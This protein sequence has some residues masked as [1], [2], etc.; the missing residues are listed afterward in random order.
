[1]RFNRQFY[2]FKDVG[3][4]TTEKSIHDMLNDFRHMFAK[5]G[6]DWFEEETRF[7]VGDLTFVV[8]K[9]T[10]LE[11]ADLPKNPINKP[12][13]VNYREGFW[14]PL[15][16]EGKYIFDGEIKAADIQVNH[17]SIDGDLELQGEDN[18]VSYTDYDD[19]WW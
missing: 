9:L 16:H 2:A 3:T 1:M 4:D 11:E 5:S 6:A 18:K 12:A 7:E 8:F 14:T 17:F 10:W 15:G 19:S 13:G